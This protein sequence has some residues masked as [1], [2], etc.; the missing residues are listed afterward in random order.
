MA[1]N[2]NQCL[3]WV[4]ITNLMIPAE[5]MTPP[6]KR[7]LAD[8]ISPHLGRVPLHFTAFHPRLQAPDKPEHPRKRC[9]AP[10]NRERCGLHYVSEGN[11]TEWRAHQFARAVED[12]YYRRSCARCNDNRLRHG[13]CRQCAPQ[14]RAFGR[15]TV[16]KQ[17]HPAH[18]DTR[19][20]QPSKS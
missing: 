17:D 11:I 18:Q 9:T 12:C 13:A 15:T 20:I 4:E 1:K 19:K 14:S 16:T 6:R 3:L 5:T 7:K 8:W 10:E 2:E